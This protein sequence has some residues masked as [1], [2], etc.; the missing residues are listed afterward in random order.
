MTAKEMMATDDP[1][2]AFIYK[3]Y[4]EADMPEYEKHFKELLKKSN[5]DVFPLVVLGINSKI[6]IPVEKYPEKLDLNT[7]YDVHE[8]KIYVPFMYKDKQ[9]G[10]GFFAKPSIRYSK[11][12]LPDKAFMNMGVVFNGSIDDIAKKLAKTTSHDGNMSMNDYNE[13][14]RV[15]SSLITPY[16]PTKEQIKQNR[17]V[18]YKR[19]DDTD[20]FS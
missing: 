8:V 20:Y 16:T 2:D 6:P 17:K 13:F 3:V 11:N 7:E 5:D 10:G 19:F 1:F 9:N 12:N 15:M 18:P 4:Y 14:K